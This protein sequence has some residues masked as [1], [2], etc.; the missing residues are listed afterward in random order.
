MAQRLLTPARQKHDDDDEVTAEAYASISAQ[1]ASWTSPKLGTMTS[2]AQEESEMI[3]SMEED[4]NTRYELEA[5]EWMKRELNQGLVDQLPLSRQSSSGSTPPISAP[6]PKRTPLFE[7]ADTPV[8]SNSS[9]KKKSGAPTPIKSPFVKAPSWRVAS[10]A[11]SGGAITTSHHYRRYH[12]AL[13]QYVKARRSLSDRLELEHQDQMLLKERTAEEDEGEDMMA[14]SSS[15][16]AGQECRAE[17]D[18]LRALNQICWAGSSNNT[19]RLKE[20]NI[21]MLLAV[22]RKLGL[23][24]LVWA[25]DVLSANQNRYAQTMFVQQLATKIDWTTKQV[26]EALQCES[27]E[28]D[29]GSAPLVLLRRFAILDWLQMYFDQVRIEPKSSMVI[30][31]SSHPDDPPSLVGE[32]QQDLLKSCLSCVLAGRME[33]AQAL[34]RSHGQSWRA[35]AWSG[36]APAGLLKV[37]NEQTKKVDRLPVGNPRR[38]LWKRQI[39]ANGQRLIDTPNI[40]EAAM[41]SLLS[42]D[43]QTCL[44]NPCLRTWE[45]GLFVI[46]YGIWGRIEDEVAHAHNNSRRNCLPPFPGTQDISNEREQLLATTDLAGMTESQVIQLLKSSPFENM[47]GNGFYE[48][49]IASVLIGKSTLLAYCG[50]EASETKFDFLEEEDDDDEDDTPHQEE[51]CRLRFL[52]HFLLYLDSLHACT[53]PIH[54]DGIEENKNQVLFLYVQHL[55]SRPELWHMLPLYASF[56]PEQTLLDY[57]PKILC[58]IIQEEERSIILSNIREYFST[59]GLDLRIVREVVRLLL[60]ENTSDATK[61]KSL[62]WLLEYDEHIGDALIC[63]NMLLRDFFLNSEDDKLGSASELVGDFLPQDLVDRAGLTAPKTEDMNP[64]VYA[65]KVD[66]ARSEYLAFLAYLEAYRVFGEWR[67][68]LLMFSKKRTSRATSLTSSKSS[69][70]NATEA[71]VA[72]EFNFREWVRERRSASEVVIEAAD[73]ARKAMQ[74]VFYHP[75]GWLSVEDETLFDA[76]DETRQR[77]LSDISCRYLVIAVSLYVQVCEETALFMSQNLDDI[78]DYLE[79]KVDRRSLF[80]KLAPSDDSDSGVLQQPKLDK[81]PLSPSYWY[82][83]ALD[84]ATIVAND[85][86]GIHKAFGTLEL[87]EFLSKLAELAVAKLMNGV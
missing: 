14:T 6:T 80:Q 41:Y 62:Q 4:E 25:D 32:A 74:N 46:L 69:L 52:T 1:L 54:L 36:G 59:V 53:T 56:L 70:L 64:A 42:N 57:F 26:L 50:L 71:A 66:R 60:R 85:T 16:L 31:V 15:T 68:K 38:F 3:E 84:V 23:A 18:L 61:C 86:Y 7:R 13:L 2:V 72:Q 81:S 51:L 44:A 77:E 37:P 19:N 40:H 5:L 22:L 27:D 8:M 24:A 33:E 87:Q 21:W 45:H 34:A 83:H 20:G 11:R 47:R 55:A 43:V 48:R 67:D 65:V 58:Q 12:D 28:S 39:W 76:E 35:A 63:A 82:Q 49:C 10:S 78:P 17:L 73:R 29:F 75:G 9:S 79:G 30:P